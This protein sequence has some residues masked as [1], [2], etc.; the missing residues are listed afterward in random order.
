MQPA[1]GHVPPPALPAL[2]PAHAGL[3]HDFIAADFDL[4]ALPI[5]DLLA[6]A[7]DP[8]VK[9]HLAALQQ[10]AAQAVTLRAARAAPTAI[11]TLEAIAAGATDNASE[12]RRAATEILRTA[13][14]CH[15]SARGGPVFS[16]L[17]HE[18]DADGL[19]CPVPRVRS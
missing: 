10:L 19:P 15:G 5:T 1:N 6:W 7:G 17:P 13:R 3:L 2:G 11:A 18:P 12:R 4:S 8:D 9:A 14:T 16:D